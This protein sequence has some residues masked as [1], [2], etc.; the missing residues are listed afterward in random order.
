MA[1]L[2]DSDQKLVDY[3]SQAPEELISEK[4]QHL[5]WGTVESDPIVFTQLLQDLGVRGAKVNEIYSLDATDF[6]NEEAVYGLIFLFRWVDSSIDR[7]EDKL[8]ELD[9]L[10]RQCWFANQVVDNA[11]GSVALLNIV[12]NA[13]ENFSETSLDIGQHLK[14]FKEFTTT[15]NPANRGSALANFDFLRQNHNKYARAAD[16]RDTEVQNYICMMERKRKRKLYQSEDNDTFHFIAFAPVKGVLWELDGLNSSPSIIGQLSVSDPQI[17]WIQTAMTRIQSKIDQYS[18]DEIRFSLMSVGQD[19]DFEMQRNLT[20]F[21]R[22]RQR[23]IT[24]LHDINPGFG[25]VEKIA[26]ET[27]HQS[28]ILLT[29]DEQSQLDAIEA[30]E[31]PESL[32]PLIEDLGNRMSSLLQNLQNKEESRHDKKAYAIQKQ[33]EYSSFLRQMIVKVLS[34]PQK[35]NQLQVEHKKLRARY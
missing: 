27:F 16:L 8:I 15:F 17:F 6:N 12:L 19:P 4:K 32:E 24:R 3:L 28:A 18:S 35:Q 2:D 33:H 25:L 7:A 11:C 13:C 20:V 9:D 10:D 14:Q 29:E 31:E 1:D 5:S 26:I 34:D 30:I 22:I 23:A 21:D